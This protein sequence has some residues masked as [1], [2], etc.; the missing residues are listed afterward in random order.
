MELTHVIWMLLIVFVLHDLEEII[1]VENWLIRHRERLARSIPAFL[2]KTFQ[3]MLSMSTAQFSVAVT[4]IFAVLSAAV[5]L[6][7][8]TWQAGTY[9]PFFLVCLHVL[10]L[11]VFTHIGQSLLFRTYTPGVVTAVV[12]VL[13][14]SVYTYYRLL[15]EG[16]ISWSMIG[17]TLPFSLLVIP[18]LYVTLTLGEKAIKPLKG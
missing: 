18:V 3:P 11:H 8:L 16:W 13:P 15:A 10:F 9:L 6:T 4:C 17:E 1:V 2:Q 14:Y 7:V 5:L 12:L